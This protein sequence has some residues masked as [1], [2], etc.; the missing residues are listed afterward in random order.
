MVSLFTTPDIPSFRG[1][2]DEQLSRQRVY[3]YF[4][5]QQLNL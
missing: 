4:F 3:I 2:E 1:C 5:K